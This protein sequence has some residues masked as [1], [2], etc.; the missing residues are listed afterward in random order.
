MK[1]S[2]KKVKLKFFFILFYKNLIHFLNK[3]NQAIILK[4]DETKLAISEI[5]DKTAIQCFTDTMPIVKPSIKYNEEVELSIQNQVNS[6]TIGNI[7]KESIITKPNEAFFESSI[8][9]VTNPIDFR[10]AT[11]AYDLV[12]NL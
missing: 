2:P 6:N 8:S 5:A 4:N 11:S 7:Q 10:N 3:E 9:R 12:Y 1:R